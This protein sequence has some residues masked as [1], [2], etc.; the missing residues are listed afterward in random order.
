MPVL[1][2]GVI[3]WLI[4]N[5]RPIKRPQIWDKQE[6]LRGE[7]ELERGELNRTH[8][9]PEC[10]PLAGKSGRELE[11]GQVPGQGRGGRTPVTRIG[12]R[13]QPESAPSWGPCGSF[14]YGSFG[15]VGLFDSQELNLAGGKG[16]SVSATFT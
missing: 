14:G 5:L 3:S 10:H 7:W 2:L 11:P 16:R 6:D 9:R 13:I 4:Y 15:P 1:G 12:T 8:N